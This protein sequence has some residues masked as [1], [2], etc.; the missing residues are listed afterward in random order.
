M[1]HYELQ[2][3]I[4]LLVLRPEGK[5]D[6]DDFR[7]VAELVDPWIEARGRLRGIMID[8]AAF[9]GW[10]DFAAFLAHVRFV[11]DHHRQVR[12]IA[13]V[14]DSPLLSIAPRLAAH[15]VAAEVRHFAPA[16]KDAARH[17]LEELSD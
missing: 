17:W 5:L 14:S 10:E 11:R 1:L 2:R 8:A 13:A 6:A 9:P 3:D 4:G 7:R 16:D 12:R 15:F